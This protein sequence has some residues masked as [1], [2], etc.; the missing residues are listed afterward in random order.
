MLL[1]AQCIDSNP[2]AV[3]EYTELSAASTQGI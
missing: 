3:A 1:E 2:M